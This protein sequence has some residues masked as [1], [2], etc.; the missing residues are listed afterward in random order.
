MTNKSNTSLNEQFDECLGTIKE[1]KSLLN[2][3][4]KSAKL[5]NTSISHNKKIIS[6]GNGGSAADAQHF[7]AEFVG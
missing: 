2:I 5:I 6:F 3:I 4:E 7:V 1:C